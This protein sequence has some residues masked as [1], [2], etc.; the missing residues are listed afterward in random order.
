MSH[1]IGNPVAGPMLGHVE[2]QAGHHRHGATGAGLE[3]VARRT[4]AR[5]RHQ[6]ARIHLPGRR[7]ELAELAASGRL[8]DLVLLAD[9]DQ[10][11]DHPVFRHVV[12]A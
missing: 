11:P 4:P 10:T 6:L 12:A 5:Q 2:S 7:I 3:A 8:E 9:P 1:D